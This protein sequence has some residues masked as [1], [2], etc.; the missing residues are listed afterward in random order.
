MYNITYKSWSEL[1]VNNMNIFDCRFCHSAV[2]SGNSG[3]KILIYGG[4]KNA[5]R[6]LDSL[7]VLCLDGNVQELEE[8]MIK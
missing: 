7:A 2:I 3:D 5:V 1:K 4:M 6:T 8:S